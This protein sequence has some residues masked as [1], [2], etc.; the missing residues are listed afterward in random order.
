MALAKS[1]Y[2]GKMIVCGGYDGASGAKEVEDGPADA[3]AF[4]Q[5]YIANPD[6]VERFRR[7]GPLNE[8]FQ[9]T[10]YTAGPTGY[11]DYPALASS[12]L[13]A[14]GGVVSVN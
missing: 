1:A 4:G 14:R 6:F 9:D 3:V 5:L 10:F 12:T 13:E 2:A 7:G 8:P 11:I